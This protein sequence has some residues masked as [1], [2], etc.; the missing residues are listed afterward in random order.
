MFEGILYY[1][2][3]SNSTLINKTSS[4]RNTTADITMYILG[5]EILSHPLI[6]VL[7]LQQHVSYCGGCNSQLRA[8]NNQIIPYFYPYMKPC[9][10]T[11]YPIKAYFDILLNFNTTHILSSIHNMQKRE[12]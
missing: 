3:C 2:P 4:R 10:P 9:I 5:T 7:W 12:K 8:L 11:P 6:F 1:S